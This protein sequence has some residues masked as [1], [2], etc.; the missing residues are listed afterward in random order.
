MPYD[1]TWT[2]SEQDTVYHEVWGFRD[3]VT[4][5][6]PYDINSF[7]VH[8]SVRDA[9]GEQASNDASAQIAWSYG[10]DP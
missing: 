4:Y 5:A 3:S 2:A 8:V 9:L 6:I 10:C 7:Q 1:F